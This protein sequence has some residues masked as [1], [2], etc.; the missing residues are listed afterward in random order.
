VS[1]CTVRED[2]ELR[3]RVDALADRPVLAVTSHSPMTAFGQK[4]SFAG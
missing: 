3:E 1:S 2:K 4:R